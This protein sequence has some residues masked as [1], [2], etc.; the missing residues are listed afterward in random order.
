MSKELTMSQVAGARISALRKERAWSRME[1]ARLTGYDP[2][3]GEGGLSD[4]RLANYERGIRQIGLEEAMVLADVFLVSPAFIVGFTSIRFRLT[5]Q[6][7]ELITD[8]RSMPEVERESLFRT[9]QVRSLSYRSN[10]SASKAMAQWAL[11][12]PPPAP[13]SGYSGRS[14]PAQKRVKRAPKEHF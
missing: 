13:P 5:P 6:E 9:V 4:T 14:T 12:S 2:A 10:A 11:D 3:T 1:L 7:R 8:F